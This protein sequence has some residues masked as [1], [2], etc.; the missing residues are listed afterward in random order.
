MLLVNHIRP[1]SQIT[2]IRIVPSDE[3]DARY[4]LSGKKPLPKYGHY[5]PSTPLPLYY[6]GYH[7]P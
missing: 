2:H 3:E 5:L 6:P 1:Y 4:F 7:T